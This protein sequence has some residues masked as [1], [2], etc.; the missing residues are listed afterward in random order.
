MSN[1]TSVDPVPSAVRAVLE[2]YQQELAEVEFPDLTAATLHT[3]IESVLERAREVERALEFVKSARDALDQTREHLMK[4]AERGL[5][6]ARIYAGD[7][8]QLTARLAEIQLRPAPAAKPR[9]RRKA[10]APA[11]G[12]PQ[13]P[14]DQV[15]AERSK[16]KARASA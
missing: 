7:D 14:L 1:E 6:Y 5:A 9:K 10:S 3:Q 2:I 11:T 8:D 4:S 15:A 12:K 13:L 16:K